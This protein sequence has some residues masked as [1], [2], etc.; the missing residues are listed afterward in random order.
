[1]EFLLLFNGIVILLVGVLSGFAF[2]N[3]IQ[4]KPEKEVAWRVVH[5]GGSMGGI[6]LLALSAIWDKLGLKNWEFS[7][8]L[9]LLLS[10]YFLVIGMVLAAIS[11]KRGLDSKSTG[12]GKIVFLLYAI[13]SGLSSISLSGLLIILIINTLTGI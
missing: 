10:T 7:V 4:N 9:G 12:A 6:M 1:M 2:S 3:A 13:G 5:S 8:G 11:G